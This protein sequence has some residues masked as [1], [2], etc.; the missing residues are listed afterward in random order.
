[1]PR[2]DQDPRIKSKGNT[3]DPTDTWFRSDPLPPQPKRP[4][5]VHKP[6]KLGQTSKQPSQGAAPSA[7]ATEASGT[8]APPSNPDN[9]RPI[10]PGRRSITSAPGVRRGD[11]RWS[12]HNSFR[13]AL[14]WH[15]V[16]DR[17]LM[18]LGVLEQRALDQTARLNSRSSLFCLSQET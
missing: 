16:L 9:Y 7:P 3:F 12:V 6:P 1:M 4:A 15:G 17:L 11:I 8:L 18:P 14:D 13:I 10:S 5:P 2:T